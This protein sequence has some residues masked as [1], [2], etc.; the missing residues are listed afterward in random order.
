MLIPKL[1]AGIV[2]VELWCPRIVAPH[3]LKVKNRGKYKRES[4]RMAT[5]KLGRLEK[6]DVRKLWSQEQYDLHGF[7]RSEDFVTFAI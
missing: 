2:S 3:I 1:C 6:V 4:E 5:I 7:E